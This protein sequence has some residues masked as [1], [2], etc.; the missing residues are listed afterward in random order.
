MWSPRFW[1]NLSN[2]LLT[3]GTFPERYKSSYIT[4]FI[5]KAGLHRMD[6]RSYWPISNLSVSPSSSSGLSHNRW[7]PICEPE[8]SYPTVNQHIGH[9]SRPRLQSYVCYR[10]YSKLPMRATLQYWFY[11]ICRPLSTR[12]TR[13]FYSTAFIRHLVLME[14]FSTGFGPTSRAAPN[15]FAV[16][17]HYQPVSV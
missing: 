4:P 1:L 11:W 16:N 8:T 10:T 13:T 2:R 6:T 14:P 17:G 5:N 3:I 12:S 15:V 7:S 9:I